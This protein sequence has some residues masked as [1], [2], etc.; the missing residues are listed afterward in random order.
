[1][2]LFFIYT[3]NALSFCQNNYPSKC[4]GT[5]PDFVRGEIIVIMIVIKL[6]SK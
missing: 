3:Y 6:S 1:M 2:L 4:F 5:S